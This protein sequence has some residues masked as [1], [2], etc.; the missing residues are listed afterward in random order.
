[1]RKLPFILSVLLHL[2]FF[3][4]IATYQGGGDS[5]HPGKVREKGNQAR[6][7]QKP[8]DIVPKVV[9]VEIITMEKGP[10]KIPAVSTPP[11]KKSPV[12]IKQCEG[13]K[14]FGGIG[15]MDDWMQGDVIEQVYAGYPA[16]RAGLKVGDKILYV[17]GLPPDIG[18]IRGEPGTVVILTISRLGATYQIPIV[19]EKICT[20][21]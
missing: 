7:M 9:D 5:G 14:W 1:M 8:V 3:L 12:G 18:Q 21:R 11:E 13:D 17:D 19:R 6:E 16:A 2:S 20:D 4:F 10:G 15:I